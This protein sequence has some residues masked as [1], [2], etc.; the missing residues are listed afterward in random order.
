MLVLRRAKLARKT[1]ASGG[2][3][4]ARVDSRNF[5]RAA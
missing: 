2:T 4:D 3:A 1:A 5:N